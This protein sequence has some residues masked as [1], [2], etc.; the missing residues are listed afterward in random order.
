MRRNSV[1]SSAFKRQEVTTDV[2]RR[3]HNFAPFV[4]RIGERKAQTCAMA[5]FQQPSC[6]AA[7]ILL[8]RR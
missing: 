3:Y 6:D 1:V 5:M 7:P 8:I 2:I 4:R